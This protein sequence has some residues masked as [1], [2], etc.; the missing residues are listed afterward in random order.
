MIGL[1]TTYKFLG[2]DSFDE[3]VIISTEVYGVIDLD[4]AKIVVET[5][6]IENEPP[7]A[8]EYMEAPKESED[9]ELIDS[10]S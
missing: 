1:K 5:K 8:P 3:P 4:G 2:Y 7:H 10:V 9:L 6:R